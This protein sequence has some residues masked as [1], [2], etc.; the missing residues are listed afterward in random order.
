MYFHIGTEETILF[1]GWETTNAGG[2]TVMFTNSHLN[3]MGH[4]SMFLL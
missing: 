4:Y 3:I 1:K 2:I